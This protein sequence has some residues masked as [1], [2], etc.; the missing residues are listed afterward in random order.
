M[1]KHKDYRTVSILYILI[2]YEESV[3]CTWGK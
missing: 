3:H 1:V 2:F